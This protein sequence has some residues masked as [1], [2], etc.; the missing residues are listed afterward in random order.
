LAANGLSIPPVEWVVMAGF[1]DNT[2]A[3]SWQIRQMMEEVAPFGVLGLQARAGEAADALWQ[4][5]IELDLRPAASL[6]FKANLLSGAVTAFCQYAAGVA[7]NVLVIARAGS[8]I[9]R[10]HIAGD[11]TVER[12]AAILKGLHEHAAASQGNVV[13]THA[14]AAWKRTLPVWGVP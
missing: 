12:A 8:G 2:A 13:L 6:S 7:E 10:G 4:G 11:L 14:L 9:V 3:V 5:L 1:E